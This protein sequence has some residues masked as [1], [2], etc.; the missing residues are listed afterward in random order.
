[1]NNFAMLN[2][3]LKFRHYIVIKIN[4]HIDVIPKSHSHLFLDLSY[5]MYTILKETMN[6]FA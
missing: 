6:E 3:S 4:F 2:V 5:F 1:M